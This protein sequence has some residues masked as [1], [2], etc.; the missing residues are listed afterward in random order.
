MWLLVG[1]AAATGLVA[2]LGT[3]IKGSLAYAGIYL[4]L[5]TFVV[6]MVL[7]GGVVLRLRA[8]YSVAGCLWFLTS[9]AAYQLLNIVVMWTSLLS[10]WWAAGQPGY[11]VGLTTAIGLVPLLGGIW[12]LGRKLATLR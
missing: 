3:L 1:L 8:H 6:A 7:M 11:H 12:K 4:A 5:G 10:G 9:V 2:A